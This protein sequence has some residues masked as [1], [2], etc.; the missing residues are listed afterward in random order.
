M[1]SRKGAFGTPEKKQD[2]GDGSI[3]R[4][5]VPSTQQRIDE[6]DERNAKLQQTIEAAQQAENSAREELLE[7]SEKIEALKAEII[8]LKEA[9]SEELQKE[10]KRKEIKLGELNANLQ[11]NQ[12][13]NDALTQ[14]INE[15]K[16]QLIKMQAEIEAVQ[17]EA[18]HA[19]ALQEAAHA[20]A[21]QEAAHAAALQEAAQHYT[22]QIITLEAQHQSV[23]NGTNHDYTFLQ[24]QHQLLQNSHN[25]L[26]TQVCSKSSCTIM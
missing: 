2:Q 15:L 21:L 8:S 3:R 22:Q 5:G 25:E 19:A 16:E 7:A 6:L 24:Q 4:S 26:E 14:K 12:M 9:C 17:Q 23:I 1:L 11:Q 18:A 10:I 13:E 20:A